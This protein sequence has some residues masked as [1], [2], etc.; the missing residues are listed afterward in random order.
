MAPPVPEKK[1]EV[2]KT[3]PAAKKGTANSPDKKKAGRPA[4]AGS[5]FNAKTPA[6]E[7]PK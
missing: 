4:A 6:D 2:K 5:S 1:E 3:S 7:A